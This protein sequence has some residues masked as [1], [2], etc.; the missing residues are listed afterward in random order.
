[1]HQLGRDCTHQVAT[2][3]GSFI[4][5]LHPEDYI[6]VSLQ[7]QI[8]T[9]CFTIGIIHPEGCTLA[10]QGSYISGRLALLSELYI[11]KIINQLN[12]AGTHQVSF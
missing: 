10:C 7:L 6:S 5:N 3:G 4:E 11:R 12:K 8:K 9:P 1:M 2:S